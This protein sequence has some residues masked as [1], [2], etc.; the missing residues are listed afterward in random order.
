MLTILVECKYRKNVDKPLVVSLSRGAIRPK[1]E[2][3]RGAWGLRLGGHPSQRKFQILMVEAPQNWKLQISKWS[4]GSARSSPQTSAEFIRG[5]R[6][7]IPKT[8]WIALLEESLNLQWINSSMVEAPQIWNPQ[9]ALWNLQLRICN[10][11][12]RIHS[13]GGSQVVLPPTPRASCTPCAGFSRRF[14]CF[15]ATA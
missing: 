1:F 11:I 4:E 5:Q 7:S 8:V 14:W 2:R 13:W 6:G 10:G 3:K 9:F 12:P 15:S